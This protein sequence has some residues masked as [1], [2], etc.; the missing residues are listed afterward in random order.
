MDLSNGEGRT[1]TVL[2]EVF[3]MAVEVLDVKPARKLVAEIRERVK[4]GK[5]L[6][7]DA[8]ATRRGLCVNCYFAFRRAKA[9]KSRAEAIELETR[10][11]KAGKILP[12]NYCRQIK[13]PNP[14]LEA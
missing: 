9:G 2:D 12:V 1:V 3:Q 6:H 10:A 7:C 14:F 13:S 8:D 11:I 5:C 4:A